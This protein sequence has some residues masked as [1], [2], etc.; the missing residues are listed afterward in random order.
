MWRGSLKMQMPVQVPS[1]PSDHDSKGRVNF[2]LF[3]RGSRSYGGKVSP[4]I[5]VDSRFE[6]QRRSAMFV[7]LMHV[8]SDVF[9]QTSFR[10]CG[11]EV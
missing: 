8:I 9:S 1:A 6:F 11:A 3:V 10:R 7:G 5:T 2:Y 4:S